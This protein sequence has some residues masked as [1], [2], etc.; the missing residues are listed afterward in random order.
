MGKLPPTGSVHAAPLWPAVAPAV[1]SRACLSH[2]PLQQHPHTRCDVHLPS[3]SASP[4]GSSHRGLEAESSIFASWPQL[5]IWGMPLPRAQAVVYYLLLEM[6]WSTV[7]PWKVLH[8]NVERKGIS[9]KDNQGTNHIGEVFASSVVSPRPAA[10]Q[11]W[12]KEKQLV[13]F[14]RLSAFIFC[15]DF[16]KTDHKSFVAHLT[17]H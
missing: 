14:Y 5:A 4:F 3:A 10:G 1:S 13:Q 9:R 16:E 2:P 17:H 6:W 15:K 7:L 12:G 8:V 11:H